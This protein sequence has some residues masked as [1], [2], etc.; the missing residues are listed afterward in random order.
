MLFL[1][2]VNRFIVK[3]YSLIKLGAFADHSLFA[4]IQQTSGH[5]TVSHTHI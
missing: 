3:A 2:V 4:L 5:I 1:A